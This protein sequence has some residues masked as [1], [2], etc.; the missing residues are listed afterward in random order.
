[1]PVFLRALIAKENPLSEL[2][3]IL[4]EVIAMLLEDG[5][6]NWKMEKHIIFWNIA[7]K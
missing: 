4:H 2:N 7:P 1:M 3:K 5:T 6:L